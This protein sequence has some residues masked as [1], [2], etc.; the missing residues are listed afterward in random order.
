MRK[1]LNR[2]SSPE[3]S[4]RRALVRREVVVLTLITLMMIG[5]WVLTLKG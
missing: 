1:R 4:A 5:A 2:K 3:T